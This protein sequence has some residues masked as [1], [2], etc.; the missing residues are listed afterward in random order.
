MSAEKLREPRNPEQHEESIESRELEKERLREVSERA[1][2]AQNHHEKSIDQIRKSIEEEEKKQ[3]TTE[4]SPG[5]QEKEASGGIIF[6]GQIKKTAYKKELRRVRSKLPSSERA[7]SAFI[8]SDTIENISEITARSVAR[9]S[10]LLSGGIFSLLG[11][12]V[13]LWMSRHYGFTYNFFV[14]IAFYDF[15]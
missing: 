14:F 3:P 15:I 2:N 1:A 4:I 5:E 6:N 12:L 11:T 7:F 8:H 10:A 13:V 9:P